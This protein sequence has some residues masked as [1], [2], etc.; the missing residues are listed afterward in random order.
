MT[1]LAPTLQAFLTERLMTQRG[2][3]PNTV[4]SYRDTFRLLLR[5]AA[6][7]TGKPPSQLDFSDLDAALIAAFLEHLEVVRQ[8]A[9]APAT[10]ASQRSTRCSPTRRSA[11][12]SMPP[13]SSVS[14]RSRSSC[15]TASSS[16]T[17]TTTRSTPCSA[18]AIS[19]P[20]PGDGTRRCSTSPSRPDRASQNLPRSS[21]LT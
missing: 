7:R 21:A 3:S 18:L 16:P 4:A 5:F 10:T 2:A 20:G 19:A 15:S 11:T 6:E 9:S 17:S 12:L 8:T 1:A 14:W 13:R